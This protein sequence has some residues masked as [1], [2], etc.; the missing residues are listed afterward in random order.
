MLK[1][2]SYGITGAVAQWIED[3]ITERK[4]KVCVNGELSSWETVT[5]GV[6]QGSVLGPLLF[7]IFINDLTEAVNCGVK[8]YADDTKIYAVVNS[9][10]DSAQFQQQINALFEWSM[11]WQLQFHP[12]KC[13]ILK[14]GKKQ[15][16]TEY[17][18]GTDENKY[19]LEESVEE[20][21]LGVI[22]DGKL[23]FTSHCD[24]VVGKANKL[25]GILRRNFTYINQTN[26]NFLYKGIIRPIIE[27][28]AP[29]YSPMLQNDIQK[30]ER[31]QRRATK[32]VIGLENESY[33]TRLQQLKLPT[34]IYRRARGDLIQVYKYLHN[35]NK[36]PEGMFNLVENSITRGHSLKLKKS[37]FRLNP[38][39]HF[40]T[41]RIINLWNELE[42]ETVSAPSINAF[43]NR[44]DKEW[45]EKEWKYNRTAVI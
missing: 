19:T 14:L 10:G 33:E 22:I 23:T 6:P 5:S 3:F 28:A 39:G 25:L 24:K 4:Q 36:C 44:L 38:R 34:L 45:E 30:I 16:K 40:F 41:Q 21:D 31:I 9:D 7:V 8:L 26:F 2:Q 12:D 13:H 18:M 29:V 27:Y 37:K 1:V 20:K 15:V 11:T 35:I 32:M 43:K 17:T 42:E